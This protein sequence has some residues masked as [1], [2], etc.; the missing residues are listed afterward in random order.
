MGWK[1]GDA[2]IF[3][4]EDDKV[5]VSRGLDIDDLIGLVPR[6]SAQNGDPPLPNVGSWEEQRAVAWDEVGE[7]FRAPAT[8]EQ[9]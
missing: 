7:R 2:L 6:L 3:T 5:V 4:I 8:E 9:A 1:P